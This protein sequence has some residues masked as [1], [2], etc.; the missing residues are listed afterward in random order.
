MRK[1]SAIVAALALS[2]NVALAANVPQVTLQQSSLP[3]DL[4]DVNLGIANVNAAVTPQAIASTFLA[5][6]PSSTPRM[7][8]E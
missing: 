6:P 5:A 7:S 4:P 2:A 3:G 8:V 1:F